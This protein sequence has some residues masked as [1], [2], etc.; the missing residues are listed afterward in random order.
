V[1][2]GSTG[3]LYNG[4]G[5]NSQSVFAL[6]GDSGG[7][8]ENQSGNGPFT[9]TVADVPTTP[10]PAWNGTIGGPTGQNVIVD[11]VGT[12][13]RMWGGVWNGTGTVSRFNTTNGQTVITSATG[14]SNGVASHA[15]IVTA[16]GV[17][18][19]DVDANVCN[20]QGTGTVN[21]Y[22]AT[23]HTLTV[24]IGVT[25]TFAGV[26]DGPISYSTGAV[27]TEVCTFSG[28]HTNTGA[29][30]AT[31]GNTLKY[32]YA[33]NNVIPATVSLTLAGGTHQFLNVSGT[34][35]IGG[36]TAT[37][38]GSTLSFSN[39]SGTVDLNTVSLGAFTANMSG[40]YS[41]PATWK[42][43][44]M[45]L[46]SDITGLTNG[47]Y[48]VSTDA[49][50]FLTAAIPSL[51]SQGGTLVSAGPAV[52]S[53]LDPTGAGGNLA[54][55]PVTVGTGVQTIG[56][57]VAN[58]YAQNPGGY[59]LPL[60][61]PSGAGLQTPSIT[62]NNQ[63]LS[64]SGVGL[65]QSATA[66]G[67][68]TID[69][70]QTVT[71]S[72]TVQNNTTASSLAKTGTGTLVL[73]ATQTYTGGTTVSQGTLQVG[74]ASQ[75]FNASAAQP[76]TV[77]SG[78]AF[79]L[80]GHA[81]TLGNGLS[82][83]A[84]NGSITIAG[85]GPSGAGALTNSVAQAYSA[86]T[87]SLVSLVLSAD[88]TVGGAGTTQLL[89]SGFIAS[90]LN[91]NGHTLTINHSGTPTNG[92]T[93]FGLLLTNTAIIGG[94]AVTI[95]K[96]ELAW[97]NQNTNAVW[98]VG[99][100]ITVGDGTNT[101]SFKFVGQTQ[102]GNFNAPITLN[103]G[104]LCDWGG[105]AWNHVNSD[106][107]LT[108]GTTNYLTSINT[109]RFHWGK[110]TG[111]GNLS[112]SHATF[113]HAYALGFFNQ[114]ANDYSG[115]TVL[116]GSNGTI[117]AWLGGGIS[118]VLEFE[119]FTMR[120][121]DVRQVNAGF[122]YNMDLYTGSGR[123][124]AHL[125]WSDGIC[126][127]DANNGKA[128]YSRVQGSAP[129]V[130]TVCQTNFRTSTVNNF[131]SIWYDGT[132]LAS[133]ANAITNRQM[134][135]YTLGTGNGGSVNATECEIIVLRQS[136]SLS[137]RQWVEGYLANKWGTTSRLPVGH[138]WKTVAPTGTPLT[139]FGSTVLRQWY[140]FSD[141]STVFTD[142]AGTIA[143]SPG[144]TVAFIADKS[145]NGNHIRQL[146]ATK[147]PVWGSA[148]INGLNT[149]KLNNTYASCPNPFNPSV[150]SLAPSGNALTLGAGNTNQPTN[151]CLMD[152]QWGGGTLVGGNTGNN[153]TR[154]VVNGTKQT[155]QGISSGTVSTRAA[156]ILENADNIPCSF[157]VGIIT[158][159]G[160]TAFVQNGYTRDM[161]N[162]ATTYKLGFTCNM[163]A[164]GVQTFAG[165]VVTYTGPTTINS[166][167]I[168]AYN[169][170]GWASPVTINNGGTFKVSNTV[171]QTQNVTITLNGGG[172]LVH[173]GLTAT[174][175]YWVNANAAT[176]ASGAAVTINDTSVTNVTGTN[177]G[178]FMDGGLK[179][180]GAGAVATISV[181]NAGNG[182]V[183]RNNNTTFAGTL[184]VNGIA[185]AT[186]NLGSGIGV[187]GCTTGLQNA[188]IQVNG[189]ME[190]LNQGVG[191]AGSGAGAFTM[192]ALSGTGV[193]IGNFTSGGTTTLTVGNTGNGGTFSGV[194]ANGTGNTTVL[195]KIGAGTQIL[196][197]VNT[198]TG[199]TTVSVGTLQIGDGGSTSAKLGTGATSVASGA[200]LVFNR[201][202]S[203]TYAAVISGAG[204]VTK[205]GAGTQTLSAACTYTGATSVLAGIL[206]L[207]GA[208]TLTSITP[209]DI[210][211]GATF[212]YASSGTST[213]SGAITGAGTFEKAAGG[214]QCILTGTNSGFTGT[215]LSTAD[216]LRIGASAAGSASAVFNLNGGGLLANTSSI[217]FNIGALTGSGTFGQGGSVTNTTATVG[218][219][220]TSTTYSGQISGSQSIVKVGTGTLTLSGTNTHTGSTTISAGTLS[221]ATIGNGGVSGNL[222]AAATAASNLIIG[223]ATLAYTGATAS[224]NRAFTLGAGL[225][226][227]IDVVSGTTLTISGG[228]T[229][230]TGQLTKNGAGTLILTGTHPATGG[231]RSNAG[232][233]QYSSMPSANT[234][235]VGMA[236][237]SQTTANSGNFNFNFAPNWSG[238]VINIIMTEPPDVSTNWVAVNFNLLG[239]GTPT[240]QVNGVTVALFLGQG[241]SGNGTH[242]NFSG[243]GGTITITHT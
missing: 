98:P 68:L 122:C 226:S 219:L 124:L 8:I 75:L 26:L 153:F 162:S 161:D 63:A 234:F 236:Q 14:M 100:P 77:S 239:T 50:G 54:S 186:V 117:C 108:A 17:L 160:N 97:Y 144:Q 194:L 99:T 170:T 102:F 164:S 235:V 4:P 241:D 134:G 206:E 146:D 147:R 89:C 131:Q 29:F 120:R 152:N 20:L 143:A 128:A 158:L 64:I 91:T 31:T 127:F 76:V 132:Q 18:S 37:A 220:N 59:V 215:F 72:T 69:N 51:W 228:N 40:V 109:P 71:L 169:A 49:S 213:M 151:Y 238:K 3:I 38:N 243:L 83:A 5:Y 163:G 66:G 150:V 113:P 133:I 22:S 56:G 44:G 47:G 232:V 208:G 166:G 61:I 115:T 167:T 92:G 2:I 33:T 79:D 27:T 195:V 36:A 222:G 197:G 139:Q 129:A 106:I 223:S 13:T 180:G 212:R 57:L 184:I 12:G 10:I 107:T 34:A 32:D 149:V 35:L 205:N 202:D 217:S 80:N 58:V 176:V 178:T 173:N 148:T 185:S 221:V 233:L 211:S 81:T 6:M 240:I 53:Y 93:G 28:G 94:G 78:A 86:A 11:L 74:T 90:T 156:L 237:A 224:S 24:N 95:A 15:N 135:A 130:G 218:A 227:K 118:N 85:T 191:W 125:P 201:A 111:A 165:S 179:G 188:D 140:D 43:T 16:P 19:L 198:Y 189:T 168:E 142:Y 42:A 25:H 193:V 55:T 242:V 192:G 172:T 116:D 174:S 231:I 30:I 177:K 48:Q 141:A 207:G 225:S 230:T 84:N 46:S 21:S 67:T 210:S 157:D 204:T 7:I 196:T 190:M 70:S 203:Q 9:V 137:D 88:A 182:V 183:F 103:K 123:F 171:L 229:A 105:Q 60:S 126:Y 214:T 145:G 138:P 181:T 187:G 175:D 82:V 65:L 101:A 136:A 216:Y 200:S 114:V 96:G 104:V 87:A 73:A 159:T 23:P 155:C 121:E 154:F 41:T 209:I 52:I 119:Y 62:N 110:I 39:C 199:T 45:P 1:N 112:T